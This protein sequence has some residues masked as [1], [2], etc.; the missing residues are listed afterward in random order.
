MVNRQSYL[1]NQR[2]KPGQTDWALTPGSAASKSTPARRVRAK[3]VGGKPS[4]R[5][6]NRLD[7]NRMDRYM[8]SV[9]QEFVFGSARAGRER[10]RAAIW[11]R[12]EHNQDAIPRPGGFFYWNRP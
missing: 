3:A 6:A 2:A 12:R 7:K 5:L 11:E 10:G 9:G 1:G 4:R 8:C